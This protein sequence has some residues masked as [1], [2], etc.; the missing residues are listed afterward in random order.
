MFT[1][2]QWKSRS[3]SRQYLAL[4]SRQPKQAKVLRV[5]ACQAMDKMTRPSAW[6]PP[7]AALAAGIGVRSV[8]APFSQ[9]HLFCERLKD[10]ETTSLSL[11]WHCPRCPGQVNVYI[12]HDAFPAHKSSGQQKLVLAFSLVHFLDSSL[13]TLGWNWSLPP[14]C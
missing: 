14:A 11:H 13:P 12:T 5:W 9:L 4:G 3:L 10:G 1:A 8:N 6:S 2:L 7:F